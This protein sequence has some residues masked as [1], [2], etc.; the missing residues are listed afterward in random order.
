MTS[1]SLPKSQTPTFLPLKSAGLVM[2]ESFQE[3]DSVPER[4]KIWAMFTRFEPAS[5]ACSTLGSQAMVNS[6]PSGADPTVCGAIVAAAGDPPDVETL[7]REVALLDRGEV[8]GELRLRV[9]LELEADCRCS[10]GTAGA[11]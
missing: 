4:W 1:N 11:R 3:T 6:G 10:A 7:G 9:P 8:A 5:R 2:F